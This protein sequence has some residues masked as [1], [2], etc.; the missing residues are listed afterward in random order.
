[1]VAEASS[2]VA[3]KRSRAGQSRSL[4]TSSVS[5]MLLRPEKD[6]IE[7]S[8]VFEEVK[9]AK[10]PQKPPQAGQSDLWAL[11]E[12]LPEGWPGRKMNNLGWRFRVVIPTAKDALKKAAWNTG[13]PVADASG[14]PEE[15]K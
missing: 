14:K 3:A 6:E 5:P 2:S 9:N 11:C 1:M 8:F 12:V 4:V 7:L 15:K 10:K 13:S